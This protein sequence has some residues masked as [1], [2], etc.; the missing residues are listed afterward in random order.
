MSGQE[1][2][3]GI[4]EGLENRENIVRAKAG[5]APRAVGV[6]SDAGAGAASEAVHELAHM[7][8]KDAVLIP[9]LKVLVEVSTAFTPLQSAAGGLLKVVQVV[10]VC[11][12]LSI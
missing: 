10:E 12:C 7:D 4:H 9:I 11:H 6:V 1:T 2:Q 8:A 5:A 3:T